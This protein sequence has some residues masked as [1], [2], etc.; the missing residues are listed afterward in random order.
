MK[1]FISWSGERSKAV[2]EALHDWLPSVIQAVEPWMSAND[3]E[4]GTRWRSGLATELEQAS[5]SL[6]CL[7]P[8]N[9]ESTWIHFEAGAL[10]KQQQNTYI[11]TFLFGLEPIDLREPL[12][13]FQATKAEQ[14]DVLKLIHTI[15]RVQDNNSLSEGKLN[16]AFDVWW[17]KLA[18][19]LSSI[20]SPQSTT[21]ELESSQD[22]FSQQRDIREI[23]A[24]IL[25]LVRSQARIERAT[26]QGLRQVEFKDLWSTDKKRLADYYE[27]SVD[28]INPFVA[29]DESTLEV[30]NRIKE[31]EEH[32]LPIPTF[33]L[34]SIQKH[35]DKSKKKGTIK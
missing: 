14:Q 27:V 22:E 30:F 23:L 18:Q 15:N 10:S 32:G 6:I 12:S 26:I 1:V 11:C 16:A 13:Q 28:D 34:N 8:E 9:L 4:K 25:E 20:S 2:A 31:A 35:S 5:V 7:T 33:H 17:P 21:N 29:I 24:E 19:Q 3:I